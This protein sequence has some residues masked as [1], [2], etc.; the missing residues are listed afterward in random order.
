V[1]SITMDDGRQEANRW[2]YE[3]PAEPI[4]A[5]NWLPPFQFDAM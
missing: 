2:Q 5:D 1:S 4:G 3:R